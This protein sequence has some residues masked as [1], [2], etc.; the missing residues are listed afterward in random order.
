[1]DRN[2]EKHQPVTLLRFE[3]GCFWIWSR[4]ASPEAALHSPAIHVVQATLC[5]RNLMWPFCCGCELPILT[6]GRTRRANLPAVQWEPADKH[7]VHSIRV[8]KVPVRFHKRPATWTWGFL[9]YLFSQYEHHIK[10]IRSEAA[11]TVSDVGSC[12]YI[13]LNLHCHHFTS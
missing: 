8:R 9:I 3:A 10:I 13:R 6:S 12:Q 4:S 1:M 2:H 5:W 11:Q 7:A